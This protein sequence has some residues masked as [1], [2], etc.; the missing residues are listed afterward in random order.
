MLNIYTLKDCPHCRQTLAFLKEHRIEFVNFDMDE[1][2]DSVVQKI[3][4]VNGGKDWVVPTMEF[5]GRWRKGKI[6]NALELEKDL[7]E[8][9]V[10]QR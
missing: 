5:G 1:Q 6:F 3:I 4:E 2:P 9:G 8:L 10:I 7:T